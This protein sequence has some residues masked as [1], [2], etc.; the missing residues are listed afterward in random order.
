MRQ[1]LTSFFVFLSVFAFAQV[2]PELVSFRAVAVDA[3]Q[4]PVTS[5]TIAIRL[6]VLD[7]SS[8]GSVIYQEI[9]HPTTD[10][11]GG[12][13][14]FI[15]NGAPT[16]SA[17]FA[18]ITWG[19]GPKYLKLEQDL[20]NGTTF[21]TVGSPTQLVSVPYALYAKNTL[22]VP[23]NSIE[24]IK[25]VYEDLRLYTDLTPGKLLFVEGYYK[26]GDGG[27]GYFLYSD[28]QNMPDNGGIYIQPN[29]GDAH[30]GGDPHQ[31]GRWV[32]LWDGPINAMYFGIMKYPDV[33]TTPYT[34]ISNTS[35]IQAAIDFIAD[36][37]NYI[38]DPLGDPHPPHYSDERGDLTLKFP[39]GQYYIDAPIQLKTEVHIEGSPGT[40]FTVAFDH[41]YDYMFEIPPGPIS[42]LYV[43]NL[44]MDLGG[45]RKNPTHVGGFHFKAAFKNGDTTLG[46]GLWGCT[47]KNIKIFSANGHGIWLEGGEWAETNPAALDNQYMLFEQIWIVRTSPDA[48]CLKIT[49]TFNTTT[50]QNCTFEIPYVYNPDTQLTQCDPGVN[51]LIE[52]RGYN[53]AIPS[54]I[55]FLNCATGG[56]VQYGFKIKNSENI[57]ID[58]N[59]IESTEIAV[60]IQ[61]SKGINVLNSRFANAGGLGSLLG[62]MLPYGQG[63]CI[64]VLDSHVTIERNYT[65]V[66]D[67]MAKDAG[68]LFIM[69]IGENNVINAR[70]NSFQNIRQSET[71]GITQIVQAAPVDVWHLGTTLNGLDLGAKRTV[72]AKG[73]RKTIM[74]FNSSIA[75]GETIF[76][77]AED[78]D[79]LFES[80]DPVNELYGRNLYFGGPSQFI[81]KHGRAALFMKL[82]G[83]NN[84]ERA[85]YQLVGTY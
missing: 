23:A 48:N 46:G 24:R 31:P 19:S 51:I 81:L 80:W 2:P 84:T 63:R 68:E 79:L 56:H 32:R 70:Y 10:A 59:W 34:T 82:D 16:G 33:Y 49:G 58:G 76:I 66:T 26:S 61:N 14:L 43:E 40:L 3:S 83:A 45:S 78:M 71:Y 50:F 22:T 85:C 69:G 64:S 4:N 5:T 47:F 17:V 36:S 39:D 9:H 28:T 60:D 7:G 54:V 20:S 65:C 73:N 44:Q 38:A 77:R 8:S 53:P 11:V 1:F 27:G 29:P 42:R 30:A 21:A 67:P 15:G 6:S 62:A 72:V 55:T 41:D 57:T 37:R 35:R 13:N 75:A 52:A 18:D 74:R 12:Y 25:T